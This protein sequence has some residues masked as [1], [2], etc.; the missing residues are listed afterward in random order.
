MSGIGQGINKRGTNNSQ[1][2]LRQRQQQTKPKS[3]ANPR[4]KVR[5]DFAMGQTS[6]E[7]FTDQEKQIQDEIDKEASDNAGELMQQPQKIEVDVVDEAAP[8]Q[9][10]E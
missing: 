6:I 1:K 4:D 5:N 8:E 2:D 10:Q 3:A 9:E 7:E